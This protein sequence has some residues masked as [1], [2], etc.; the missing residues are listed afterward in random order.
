MT[1]NVAS[2]LD[3]LQNMSTKLGT[4]EASWKET[5]SK[6]ALSKNITIAEW[7]ALVMHAS[8]TYE[9]VYTLKAA[10]D[11]VI[12][13]IGTSPIEIQDS[14]DV[15]SAI[16]F[17]NEALDAVAD[18]GVVDGQYDD[19]TKHIIL[20]LKNGSTISFSIANIVDSL[21]QLPAVGVEDNGKF[22]RVQN[23]E[24]AVIGIPYAEEEAF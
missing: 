2:L 5:L 8:R 11:D 4:V 20:T 7:D 22:L 15:V 23:G 1:D 14:E 6:N 16:N 21:R 17:L 12:R 9:D 18:L 10:I 13:A 24:W 19:A 3:T